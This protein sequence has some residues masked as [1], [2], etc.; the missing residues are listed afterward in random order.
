MSK[1]YLI[2]QVVSKI[3][4]QT[5]GS[6]FWHQNEVKFPINIWSNTLSGPFGVSTKQNWSKIGQY[7]T[8]IKSETHENLLNKYWMKIMTAEKEK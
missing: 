7:L 4:V 3:N 8:T 2:I 5:W 6:E 1:L